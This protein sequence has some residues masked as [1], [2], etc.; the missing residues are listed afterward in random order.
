MIYNIFMR[1]LFIEDDLDSAELLVDY[2]KGHDYQI[3]HCETVTNGLSYLKQNAYDILLLDL[4]LPD[5]FGLKICEEINNDFKI[6]IIILSAYSDLETKLKSFDLGVDDYMSK[7]YNL[8]ELNARIKAVTNRNNHNK[9]RKK[10][11]TSKNIFLIDNKKITFKNEKLK[12]TKMEFLL[13]KELI[14]NKNNIIT[15]EH[16]LQ[17]FDLAENSRSIDYHINN[18][19]K[20]IDE[21]LKKP[22][23]LI[24]EYGSGYKLI[25]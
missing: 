16:L 20:K 19:R 7:P 17:K 5:D 12:L 4:N 3:T 18:I 25:F 1:I 11:K 22:K 6:P 2:M 9:K 14:E 15:R 10:E 8:K 21:N 23:Y 13:L 24:T